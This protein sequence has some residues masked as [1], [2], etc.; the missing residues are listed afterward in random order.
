MTTLIITLPAA[1]AD[2]AALYD[3]VLTPDGSSVAGQSRVPLALLPPVSHSDEV[4]AVVPASQLSWHQVQLPKGT[5]GRRFLQDSSP[6]R[7]RAI[8]DG[9]LEDRLLDDTQNLH[10]ALAPEAQADSPVW[11]AVCDRAWLQAA[12]QALESSGHRAARIV[13]AFTPDSLGDTLYVM[14]EP[15]APQL[16]FTHRGGVTVWPLSKASVALAAWPESAPVVAEPAVLA[17]AESLFKRTI[18]LQPSADPLLQAAASPWDLAQFDLVNSSRTR[19]FKRWSAL[20]TSLL[21]SP[22]WRAA[23]LALV[24]L[25]VVNL[26]GLNAW[27]WKERS[28][29][30][31]QRLAIDAVL[32]TTFPQVQVVVD[33]PFQMAREVAALQQA[34]GVVSPRDLEAML[35]VFAAVAPAGS[36]PGAVDFVAGE[37]RL[38]GLKLQPEDVGPLSFQLKPLGYA[39]TPEGDSLVIKQ[40]SGL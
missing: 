3:Y 15:E 13:P 16:V 40:V 27:A 35:A 2:T 7:V 18:A 37:L 26:I 22:R 21:R 5:L 25:L 34:S 20:V 1:P 4:V 24:A 30:K 32:T 11:V 19:T 31:A 29:L 36:V 6:L 33:A 39:A 23:R 14:G 28:S 12:L 38:K 8:L 17:L 10:F 9:L